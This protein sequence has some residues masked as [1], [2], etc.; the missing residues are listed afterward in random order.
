M[1]QQQAEAH[2]RFLSGYTQHNV[3]GNCPWCA[4]TAEFGIPNRFAA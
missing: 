2:V 1:T 3:A 4:L